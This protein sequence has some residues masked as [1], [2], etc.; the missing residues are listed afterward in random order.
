[1]VYDGLLECSELPQ[2]KDCPWKKGTYGINQCLFPTDQIPQ[3]FNGEYRI[4][5]TVTRGGEVSGGYQ[6]FF[7]VIKDE[8]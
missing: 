8:S 2:K 4:D 5:V 3:Y 7:Y 6:A 1:M